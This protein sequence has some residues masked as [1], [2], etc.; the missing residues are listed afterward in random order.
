MMREMKS[1]ISRDDP[2]YARASPSNRD[3]EFDSL[4]NIPGKACYRTHNLNTLVDAAS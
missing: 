4:E 1:L 2:V 3:Q